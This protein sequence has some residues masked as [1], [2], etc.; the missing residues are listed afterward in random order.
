MNRRQMI[1]ATG[2]ALLLPTAA[3]A[4][5]ADLRGDIAILREALTM[6]PGLYR[7]ATPRMIAARIDALEPAFIAAPT[8]EARYL[9]LS[10]F[11][12]TIRCGHSYCN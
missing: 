10:R 8:L 6:H 1:T 3:R 9:L 5:A 2:A 4:T 12:A 11:Q 7:Y